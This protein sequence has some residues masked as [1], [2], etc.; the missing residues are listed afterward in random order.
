MREID[1]NELKIRLP[2]DFIEIKDTREVK[3]KNGI[4]GQEEA[5]KAIE[6]GLSIKDK[7][8]NIFVVGKSGT[9]RTSAVKS[10]M[11]KR[12]LSETPAEDIC[13]AYNFDDS[14]TPVFIKLLPG[15]GKKFN[16]MMKKNIRM[17][18][19]N[20]DNI[21]NSDIFLEKINEIRGK[22][23][24]EKKKIFDSLS[25]EIEKDG[26][27][28]EKTDKGFITIPMKKGKKL[29]EEEYHKLNEKEKE[30]IYRKR[31]K[32]NKKIDKAFRD[33]R[34]IDFR[35][36]E[37]ERVYVEKYLENFVGEI[38][39][40]IEHNFGNSYNLKKLLSGMK[41]N[42]VD[43]Y[44]IFDEKFAKE[45][46]NVKENFI[47]RF[48][49]NVVVDN[50]DLQGAPVII[51]E[52]PTYTNLM[53]KIERESFMGNLLTDFSLIT[54]GSLLKANGGYLIIN[55]E[56]LLANP[57]AY[58]AL[59]RTLQSG[60]LQIEDLESTLGTNY[61][62]GIKPQPIP[63]KTKIVL[64]GDTDTYYSL[65]YYDK[66]FLEIFKVKAEFDF[67]M[68]VTKE[69][70]MDFIKFISLIV[71]KDKLMHV[72]KGGIIKI[73]EYASR[74]VE[75]KTKLTTNFGLISS[76]I[77]EANYIAKRKKQD[78]IK[79]KDIKEAIFNREYRVSLLKSKSFEMIKDNKILID[80]SGKKVGI[81]KGLTVIMPGDTI[82][83]KPVK[84]SSSI[85]LGKDGIINIERESELSGAIHTKGVLILS[86]YMLE[87]F[88]KEFP[89]SLSAKIVFEQTYDE[90]DGD[91]ASGAELI[92]ILS[93]L[94]EIPINQG[95]AITGS[96]SQKGEIQPIGGVNYKIEGFYEVCKIKGLTGEQGVII[97]EQNVSDLNL[98]DEVIDA[99]RKGKFK[100]IA[101]K[102]I[103]EAASLLMGKDIGIIFKKVSEK[104]KHF[105]E[106][107]GE[108]E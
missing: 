88:S 2:E 14:Y 55:A 56:E 43:N 78:I 11:E 37:E 40:E 12:G 48:F 94:A 58:K 92:S 31:E 80:V 96:M 70:I 83:G 79:S 20:M 49:L 21:F 62:K 25:K 66:E 24:R 44:N 103:E 69:N 64:I 76:I 54:A 50:S 106:L 10:Y 28:L 23:E 42:I 98:K 60:L 9:G 108:N 45:H 6:F 105:H 91:S 100:I 93:S 7:G 82:F 41:K 30:K 84:I 16:K 87:H 90:I 35:T 107:M 52:N 102:T 13:F 34:Q 77:K 26:F 39:E 15:L 74:M 85:G 22:G 27:V 63:I 99:V 81:I 86:G 67:E 4:I 18:E 5:L 8:F 36:E 75:D 3:V 19:K 61:V 68:P 53:G 73:I 95:Y 65:L 51:E 17:I 57:Y 72:D 59:K 1:V 89:L 38:F 104:L 33:T 47:N 71:N 101:V 29:S 97:P 46:P 32:V